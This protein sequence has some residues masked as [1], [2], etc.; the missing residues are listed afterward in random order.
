MPDLVLVISDVHANLA[1]LKAVLESERW[2]EIV[3]LGDAV[4]YGPDPGDV[5]DLLRSLDPSVALM[6]NHDAAVAF[7]V[8][9][10]CREDL[11]RLSEYV[12][13]KVTL[14]N[15]SRGDFNWL[16]SL[17][18][19]FSGEILGREVFAVH[20]S[21][22]NPLHGY[23]N[24]DLPEV[25]K[26]WA[27]TEATPLGYRPIEAKLVLLGHTH[28]QVDEQVG[29]IRVVNPGSVGQPRDG[30][31]LASYALISEESVVLRRVEYD[32]QTTVKR[33]E[34]L[35]LEEWAERALKEILLT[36]KVPSG[37][38]GP[39]DDLKA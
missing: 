36:G 29:D 19:K 28:V 9:C 33:I 30:A 26:R 32:V 16:R 11:R 37:R 4:D 7:G 21:P 39:S 22:R 17:R 35:G 3:F 12:R 20:G 13:E 31:P 34:G 14:P 6:G 5:V 2:E 25:E 27:L 24:P 18:T 1:A 38:V 10:G 23:L 8:G 15:L